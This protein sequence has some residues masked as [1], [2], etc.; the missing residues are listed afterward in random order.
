AGLGGLAL[1][2]S[3]QKNLNGSELKFKVRIFERENGPTD[4]WQGYCVSIN[5]RGIISLLYCLPSS[6]QSRLPEA[7]PDPV[8]GEHHGFTSIDDTGN[9]LMHPPFGQTKNVF[10]IPNSKSE[11]G[12][13]VSYRDKLRNLLLEDVN[14]EWN[15]KCIG[16]EE[17]DDG[18]WAIFDDGSRAF[19]DFFVA[20]DGINSPI[21]RQKIPELK[22]MDLGVTYV[23]V[24]IYPNKKLIDKWMPYFRNSLIHESLGPNGDTVFVV[25]RRIPV[26][27]DIENRS[28][29]QIHYRMSMYYSYDT[30]LDIRETESKN[31]DLNNNDSVDF[32]VNDDDPNSVVRHV[33]E[34]IKKLRKPCELRDLLIE[35][36]ECVPLATPE[37]YEKYPFNTYHAPRRRQ[38][39]DIDPLSVE[40]WETTRVILLGDAAHAMT[41]ILGLGAN[42]A[43]QDAALLTKKLENFEKEGWRKCFE[44]YEQ[45]MRV[46]SSKGVLA[47]REVILFEK[48]Q[49]GYIGSMIRRLMYR[50]MDIK[51]NFVASL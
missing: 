42:R 31:S 51:N 37:N 30:D 19:G 44:Q 45:E 49:K 48:V 34:R 18:V 14:V 29:D 38:M 32:L 41:S 20:S 28:D 17:V 11:Y 23:I 1:Y 13:I 50:V 2:H 10:E 43:L 46:K 12:F 22:V 36:W 3:I 33:I 6:L 26:E 5:K 16:Y 40:P 27:S 24:E 7:M 35:L 25:L 47:S 39:R 15:K 21:R 8:P 9:L 4:R